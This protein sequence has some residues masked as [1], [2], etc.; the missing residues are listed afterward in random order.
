ML[1][2]SYVKCINIFMD[3]YGFVYLW[4]DSK[5]KMFYIGSHKGT[6]NDGYIC[7][8]KHMY[9]AYRKRPETFR[10]KIL[11]FC[12]TKNDLL[13]KEQYFLNLI[14]DSELYYKNKKYYNIKRFA[15]GGDTL[16]YH[17]KREFI[18]KKRYGKKHSDAVKKAIKNRS[19]EKEKL[20]QERR[21]LSLRKTLNSPN[22]KNY[23][24][25]PFQ[26]YKNGVL[27]G[28]FRNK[29]QFSKQFCIDRSTLLKHICNTTWTV[30]YERKHKFNKGDKLDFV[31]V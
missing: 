7:S 10:R 21:K 4:R 29:T 2:K 25:K 14:K 20:H 26:V 17:P 8:N 28:T 5:N 16:E 31:Y 12:K 11:S 19:P 22:Y 6:L 23:Q 1:N 18:I 13:F 24:D 9:R 3:N 15:A 30:Q 27:L